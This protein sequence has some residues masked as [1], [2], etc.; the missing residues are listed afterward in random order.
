MTPIIDEIEA[1]RRRLGVTMDALAARAGR[2]G[3]TYSKA[4][5]GAIRPSARTIKAFTVAIELIAAE[6]A[7]ARVRLGRI[8]QSQP[9]RTAA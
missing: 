1:A 8:G 6:Q 3:S 4:V 5:S 7:E 2:H 9:E